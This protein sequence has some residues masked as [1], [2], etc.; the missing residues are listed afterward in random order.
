ME[1]PISRLGNRPTEVA[2]CLDPEI[3]GL[4]SV[5]EGFGWRY[6]VCHAPRQVRDLD[7]ERVVVRTPEHDQVV[8]VRHIRPSGGDCTSSPDAPWSQAHPSQANDGIVSRVRPIWQ[9]LL[10]SQVL[11]RTVAPVTRLSAGPRRF[12]LEIV[13][14]AEAVTSL[15]RKR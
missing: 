6:T 12:N 5:V 14:P 11:R 8:L 13:S 7:D 2:S 4:L 15:R 3:D 1:R 10:W 9:I